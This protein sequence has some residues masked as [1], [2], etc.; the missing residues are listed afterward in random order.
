VATLT[1]FPKRTQVVIVGGGPAGAL[2]ALML[3]RAGVAAIETVDRLYEAVLEVLGGVPVTEVARRF[4]VARQSV[5]GW[6]R[7]YGQEGLQVLLIERA[8]HIEGHLGGSVAEGPV[9]PGFTPTAGD[10]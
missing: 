2:L 6:L 1:G 7:R 4:G 3:H 8:I 10:V 9:S 5:H